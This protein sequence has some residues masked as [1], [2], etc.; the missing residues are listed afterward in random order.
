MRKNARTRV[1]SEWLPVLIPH[2]AW[3]AANGR[4]RVAPGRSGIRPAVRR[5]HDCA[6][7]LPDFFDYCHLSGV[8]GQGAC[9][10][11]KQATAR[12]F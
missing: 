2:G 10:P 7:L 11:A 8:G 9:Q 6:P 12:E 4:V 5:L 1:M 3:Y